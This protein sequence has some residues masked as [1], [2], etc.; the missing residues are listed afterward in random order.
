MRFFRAFSGIDNYREFPECVL[1]RIKR[2]YELSVCLNQSA[3]RI[4]GNRAGGSLPGVHQGGFRRL[5]RSGC[6]R[7]RVLSSFHTVEISG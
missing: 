3:Y 6:G 4:P 7:Q 2:A 5:G 1:T